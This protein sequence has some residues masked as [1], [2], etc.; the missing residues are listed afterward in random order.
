MHRY[1]KIDL[2]EAIDRHVIGF[3][4]PLHLPDDDRDTPYFFVGD[5]AFPLCT[6]MMKPYSRLGLAVPERKYNYRASHCRRVSENAFGI[7]ANRY[8]CLLSAI[9]FQPKIATN[10]VLAAIYCH[11]LIRMRYPAIQNAALTV[12]MTTIP[13]EW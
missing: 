10:I 3:P 2:K 6:F 8:A 1:S 5:D 7:L 9:K 13:G 12:R 4:P 11:N